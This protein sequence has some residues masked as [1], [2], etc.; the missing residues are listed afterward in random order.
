MINQDVHVV[1]VRMRKGNDHQ[2]SLCIE[3]EIHNVWDAGAGLHH[4]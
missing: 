4:R 3:L 2:L 1:Y